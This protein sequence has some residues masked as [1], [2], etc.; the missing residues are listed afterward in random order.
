MK[1]GGGGGATERGMECGDFLP[2]CQ[3]SALPARNWK[4]CLSATGP[5]NL[6]AGQKLRWKRGIAECTIT[7]RRVC[8]QLLNIVVEF[9]RFTDEVWRCE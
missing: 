7:S 8:S 5:Q 6:E 9:K 3:R 2:V 1:K 4:E